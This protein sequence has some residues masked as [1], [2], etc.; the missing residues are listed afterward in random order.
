MHMTSCRSIG[1]TPGRV[2]VG[3]MTHPVGGRPSRARPNIRVVVDD[4]DDSEWVSWAEA[5]RI[6]RLPVHRIEWWKRQGRIEHRAE[7]KT[8]PTLR[9]TSVEDFGRW[10]RER[11]LERAERREAK[12]AA[13]RAASAAQR[14]PEP[15]AT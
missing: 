14:P 11:E 5:A 3:G 8:R 7:D 6:T 4:A 12:L 10:Y 15:S 2:I 9:R 1:G 13:R